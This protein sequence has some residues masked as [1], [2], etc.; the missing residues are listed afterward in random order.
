MWWSRGHPV[1][2]GESKAVGPEASIVL[3]WTLQVAR[4]SALTLMDITSTLVG[5]LRRGWRWEET[6]KMLR[7]G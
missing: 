7:R 3:Y 2:E 4:S 6:A 5:L 1:K